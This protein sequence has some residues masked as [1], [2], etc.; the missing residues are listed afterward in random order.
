[1]T[2]KNTIIFFESLKIKT[3]KKSEIKV[4]NKFI[5]ILSK[6]ENRAFNA[7]E[8]KSIETELDNLNLSSNLDNKNKFFKKA[9]SKFENYLKEVFSL[10]TKGH[11]TN[12]SVSFGVLF[13]V[14]LGVLLGQRIEKSMALSFSISM[15]MFIGAFIGKRLDAK[16]KATGNLL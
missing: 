12:L 4:Y 16:A 13:G 10:T 3:T 7:N 2:L 5:D 14:V 9:L 15:G 8:I 1:M 11:Y 6:L